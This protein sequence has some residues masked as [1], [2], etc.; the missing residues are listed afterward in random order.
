MG[1]KSFVSVRL[2]IGSNSPREG[3]AQWHAERLLLS[4]S[5]LLAKLIS[6]HWL[7]QR[8]AQYFVILSAVP[9]LATRSE[10]CLLADQHRKQRSKK[11]RNRDRENF[12]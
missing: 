6:Q 9:L 12:Y 8:L 1:L 2:D 10:P 5:N 11:E 4:P 3:I 7:L